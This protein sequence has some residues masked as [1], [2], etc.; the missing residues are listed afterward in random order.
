MI[1]RFT[2]KLRELQRG[3]ADPRRAAPSRHA[4]KV[5]VISKI[6]APFAI[7]VGAGALLLLELALM[8]AFGVRPGRIADIRLASIVRAGLPDADVLGAADL[9]ARLALPSR[10]GRMLASVLNLKP[11]PAADWAASLVGTPPFSTTSDVTAAA[12]DL[13]GRLAS[14]RSSERASWLLRV[15]EVERAMRDPD[16]ARVITLLANMPNRSLR[17]LVQNDQLATFLNELADTAPERVGALLQIGLANIPQDPARASLIPILQTLDP[18]MV[19]VLRYWRSVDIGQR[20][21]LLYFLGSI[22]N[23]DRDL[24]RLLAAYYLRVPQVL[25]VAA[26]LP[27]LCTFVEKRL[28]R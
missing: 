24:G 28:C 14:M 16:A 8:L 1:D 25:H 19:Q 18:P 20:N 13:V 22:E 4:G 27:P 26:S 5:A 23:K 21:A 6:P 15:L 11:V 17:S 12:G 3:G 7:L 2:T 10:D 9:Q